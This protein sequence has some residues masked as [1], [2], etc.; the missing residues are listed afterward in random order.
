M[1][2]VWALVGAEVKAASSLWLGAE[3]CFG[4]V[5]AQGPVLVTAS[6]ASG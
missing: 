2:G 6:L 4:F 1:L 3:P 5:V